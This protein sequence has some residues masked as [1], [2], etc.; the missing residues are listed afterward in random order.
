MSITVLHSH[1]ETDVDMDSHMDSEA[2]EAVGGGGSSVAVQAIVIATDASSG[3]A[4]GA[5]G[6]R[7]RCGGGAVDDVGP[8]AAVKSERQEGGKGCIPLLTL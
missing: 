6:V 7:R 2:V 8:C 3:A 5:G 4:G 1:E